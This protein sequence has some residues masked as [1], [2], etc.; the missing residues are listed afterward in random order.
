M[1]IRCEDCGDEVDENDA[2]DELCPDCAEGT[3]WECPDPCGTLNRIDWGECVLCGAS[4][5]E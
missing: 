5:P 3:Y 2:V 4:A 1:L